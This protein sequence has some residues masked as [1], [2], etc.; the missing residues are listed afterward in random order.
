MV[1]PYIP[2]QFFDQ[3]A[4]ITN[5][6][7]LAINPKFDLTIAKQLRKPVI[8]KKN[9]ELDKKATKNPGDNALGNKDVTEDLLQVN[10]AR[11]NDNKTSVLYCEALI[12]HIQFLLIVNSG[13]AR[14]IISLSL[15]KDLEM[16]ITRASKTVMVNINSER[17]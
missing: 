9:E 12:K 7:L 3:K 11:P 14:S 15:L 8:Q 4:D 10:T 17:H 1:K 6:Q 5:G 16:E 2:Q 13:S